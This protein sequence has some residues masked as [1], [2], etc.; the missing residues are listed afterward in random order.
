[1][2]TVTETRRDLCALFHFERSR[3]NTLFMEAAKYPLVMVCAGAGYGKTSAVHDFVEK[4]QTTTAWVQLSERDNVGA[5]FWENYTHTLTH[6][7]APFAGAIGK[8]GF[9][10]TT[11]KL[12]QY[13][14]L[15]RTHIGLN[16]LVIVFDD[17][18]C[19]EAPSVIR[20][21]EYAYLNMTQGTSLFLLS[22]S[23][24]LINTAALASK[25][26]LFNTSEND[27]RF[28]DNELAQYFRQQE[29]F[30]QPDNLREIMRDTEGWAF[31]LNLIV[32]SYRKAPGYG[33]YLR[34]AMKTN[35]FRL[36]DTEIWDKMS[37]RLQKF[38]VRL[39]LI[40]HLS[41]DLLA[42]LAQGDENLTA[43]F[44]R[45]N[46]YVRRD[47]YINAY[48]IHPLFLE[49]L[50]QKQHLL[51]EEEK[52]ETYMIAGNWC[53]KNGFKIDALSYYE[54]IGDFASIVEMFIELPPQIPCDFA[55]YAAEILDRTPE[56]AFDTVLYLASEHVRSYMCQ[57][58]WQKAIALAEQYEKKYLKLAEG[59]LFRRSSLASL[60]YCMAIARAATQLMK[61][62]FDFDL[63][64]EKLDQCFPEPI[65]PGKLI[66]PCPGPWICAVG[67]EKKGALEAFIATLKRSAAYVSRCFNG[68]ETGEDSLALGEMKFYQGDIRAAEPPIAYALDRARRKGQFEIMHRALF[69]SLR[70]AVYQGNYDRAEQA[71]KT[72]KS[73][74]H[75]QRYFNRFTNYDI[76]LCWYY[77]MLGLP[78]KAPDWFQEHFSPYGYAGFIEN[79][80][81]QM[82][83]LFFYEA[84]HYP[85]LLSYIQEMKQRESF[86]FGRLEMLVLEACVFYKIKEKNLAFESLKQAYE[87]ALPNGLVMPFIEMG[88]DMRTL[89]AS[90][91]KELDM[92]I[93]KTWLEFVNRK[94]ASYAKHQAHVATEYKRANNMANGN[95]ISPREIEILTDLSHG[96]SRSAIAVSRSLSI[97]TVKMVINNVYKKL[98]AASLADLIRIA[99]ELKMI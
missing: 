26:N 63:Y 82:K 16:P 4:Y 3:L 83:A 53:N 37:K 59:D 70:I 86:L 72:M 50:S 24:P 29:I 45:Q 73:H 19:I 85:P 61:E 49:F 15:V 78:E 74:L 96:L 51:S 6:V 1:M 67:S 43:E 69:Y 52:R 66:N 65:D 84:R 20:F 10:D 47:G 17:F 93:P 31:A 14:A 30:L 32:R 92:G 46:A 2:K 90:A 77:C 88:K 58:Q 79:F 48:L 12:N 87:T 97:N 39:S 55:R 38:S 60:Y 18:H 27:L 56:Q 42:L 54:K 7:N 34:N 25:G 71:L 8:L 75:E 76:S 62:S 5:R 89:T 91:L 41:I 9:P 23:T 35:I 44:E 57:G 68:L 95:N 98:G 64:F 22:R 11:N 40:D 33:G 36:M 80:E 28:T 99:V 13:L 81:N 21:V 94:A